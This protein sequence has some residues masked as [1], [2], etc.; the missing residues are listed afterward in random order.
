[1]R[2]RFGLSQRHRIRP[3]TTQMRPGIGR[4]QLNR[5]LRE[6]ERRL[7]LAEIAEYARVNEMF[8][9]VHL[10]EAAVTRREPRIF[11]DGAAKDGDRALPAFRIEFEMQPLSA[12]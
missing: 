5:S 1:M 7:C 3:A 11:L 2:L 10:H 12:Q 6:F 8:D 9:I 4:I